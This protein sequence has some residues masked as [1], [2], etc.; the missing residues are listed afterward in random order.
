MQVVVLIKAQGWGR[1]H[2]KAVVNSEAR[3][4][5]AMR[6]ARAVISSRWK[7]MGVIVR[8]MKRMESFVEARLRMKERSEA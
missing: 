4:Q 7:A 1:E 2:W 5:R 8:R 6:A 3:A